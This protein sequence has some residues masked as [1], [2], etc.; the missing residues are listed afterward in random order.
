MDLFKPRMLLLLYQPT[1]VH[2]LVVNFVHINIIAL[3]FS[4]NYATKVT[5]LAKFELI[6]SVRNA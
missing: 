5:D 3:A 2:A 1:Q 4:C 6:Q